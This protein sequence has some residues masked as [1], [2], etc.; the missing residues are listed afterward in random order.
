MSSAEHEAS[1][2]WLAYRLGWPC[3]ASV[4]RGAV[5]DG[6][7][8]ADPPMG[9]PLLTGGP[10]L[11]RPAAERE[12][13]TNTC[14]IAL[15][16]QIGEEL[17]APVLDGRIVDPVGEQ[18]AALLETPGLAELPELPGPADQLVMSAFMDDPAGVCD[19]VR[20]AEW[21]SLAH[22]ADH[23]GAS[24]WLA[25]LE[26]E[27]RAIL[28]ADV[29]QVRLVAAALQRDGEMSSAAIPALVGACSLT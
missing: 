10:F 20:A 27:A 16:G 29:E 13:V 25:W 19:A 11:L 23:V 2:A 6:C 8:V 5:A 7:T 12:F 26:S 9:V 3:V 15:A 14:L 21:A 17:L 4:N 28:A 22:G 18:A 1:H 24:R